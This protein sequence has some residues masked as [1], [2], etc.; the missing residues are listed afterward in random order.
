MAA[1]RSTACP[2]FKQNL[3]DDSSATYSGVTAFTGANTHTGPETHSGVETHSGAETHSGDEVFSGSPTG[4]VVSKTVTFTEDATSTTH[5]GTVEIPAGATLHDV[6]FMNTVLWTGGTA[7]FI[8]GDDDDPNGWLQAIDCKAT[9]LVVGEVF[10]ISGYG[11]A[12]TASS[13]WHG[14]VG[15][16]MVAATGR[17]G[18]TG[19]GD[20][21]VYY[22]AASEIIGVMTVGT[23]ATTAGRSFMTVTYSVGTVTAATS[24]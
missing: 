23:P 13:A 18:R 17:K 4:V 11:V 10:S 16:Y 6:Q 15:D 3:T 12:D 20:S 22:G 8:I 2:L 9:E 7:V 19:A 14:K 5:T 21:G 24:A 1:T